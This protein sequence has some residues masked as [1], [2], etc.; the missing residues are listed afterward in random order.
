[1]SL[2]KDFKSLSPTSKV[3]FVVAILGVPSA[4]IALLPD[5]EKPPVVVDGS[6]PALPPDERA[7]AQRTAT[8]SMRAIARDRIPIAQPRPAKW[9]K[10]EKLYA[11]ASDAFDRADYEASITNYRKAFG[12][13]SDVIAASEP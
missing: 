9:L 4:L 10:A 3:L 6:R 7:R 12:L 2:F 1:M 13:Y 5:R 11:G 8:S